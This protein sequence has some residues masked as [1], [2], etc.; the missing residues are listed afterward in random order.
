MLIFCIIIASVIY[1]L[2]KI[3]NNNKAR[4]DVELILKGLLFASSLIAILT[5]LGII[6]SLLFE[7]IKFL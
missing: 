7:S 4:D 3:K 5:T 6:F 2:K 1:S